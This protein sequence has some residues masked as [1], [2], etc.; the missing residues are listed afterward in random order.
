V[1]RSIGVGIA[2]AHIAARAKARDVVRNSES[3]LVGRLNSV[4]VT[5]D[6]ID[7]VQ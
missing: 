6:R 1:L 7:F 4:V 3:R 2:A 5:L